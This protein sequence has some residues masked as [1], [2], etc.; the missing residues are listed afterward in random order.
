MRRIIFHGDAD[1]TVHPSNASQI[2]VAVVGDRE[3]AQVS[4]KS[5]SG[6]AYVQSD[7]ALPNG[8][9]DV[10]LWQVDG[11]GHAWSGGKAGGTYTDPKGPDASSEMVRF[12][13][14]GTA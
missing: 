4:P 3:P 6:R 13:L 2:V 14:A 12:F 7:Y 11:A 1:S 8:T 5:A 9:I 10:E